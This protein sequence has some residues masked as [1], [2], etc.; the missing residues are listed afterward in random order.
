MFCNST[1]VFKNRNT[2][3]IMSAEGNYARTNPKV[4]KTKSKW[5]VWPRFHPAEESAQTR[6]RGVP[7]TSGKG[8]SH[9]GSYV[10]ARRLQPQDSRSF[11]GSAG[12]TDVWGWVMLS[13]SLLWGAIPC[14]GGCL[15]APHTLPT[16]HQRHPGLVTTNHGPEGGVS[17]W[18]RWESLLSRG[19]R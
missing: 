8:A 6:E 19:T 3:I 9:K 4:E 18:L 10:V 2:V 15:P 13:D 1:V 12:S 17:K 7:Q 11:S 14:T 5:S 16:R